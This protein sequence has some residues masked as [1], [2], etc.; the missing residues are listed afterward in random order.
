MADLSFEELANLEIT[1]VSKRAQRLSD[2]AASIFVITS[3]DIRRSGVTSLPEALRLA[4]NLQVAQSSATA[5]AISARG[6]NNNTANKLLVMIDGRSVYTPLYSGVFWDVQ[7]VVLEDVERIEVISGPGGTLWGANAVNGVINIITR[8]AK[9]SEGGLIT[10]GAGNRESGSTV[11]YGG[12]L[13]TEGSYRIYAKYFDRRATEKLSGSSKADGWY[14]SQVGFRADWELPTDN[15]MLQGNAYNGSEAQLSANPVSVS[16]FNVTSRWEH[17]LSADSSLSVQAYFDRTERTIPLVFGEH[18]DIVDLQI[19]HSLVMANAHTISWGLGYRLAED[20]VSNTP[21]FGFLPANVDQHWSNMFV[22]DEVSLTRDLQ[23]TVGARVERNDYTG[24]EWLPNARL[25]WK[26]APEHLLWTAVSRTVRAPSRLD[27]DTYVPATPPFQLAGGPSF[28]S[29]VAKVVELGYRGQ[30]SQSMSLSATV[31]RADYDNLRTLELGPSGT[32]VTLG[33]G[34]QGVV[35]GVEMWGTYKASDTWRISA[36]MT[37]MSED[38]QVKAGS[39]DT[40]SVNAQAGLDPRQRWMFKSS[41]DLSGGSEL[42]CIVRSVSALAN[43]DVPAYV[44]LDLRYA[45]KP[46]S[47]L[48]FSVTGKNLG[49]S[50][51]EFANASTR[52]ELATAVFFKMVARF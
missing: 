31:F 17:A 23:L 38:L 5:Y 45:W 20:R 28:V 37:A 7:D 14:K 18:L 27:V 49:G 11:R 46:R 24:N 39:T 47:G 40:T 3:E 43:P 52:A 21:G 12:S 51:G 48:E 4:P 33:N 35:Q 25:A 19:Q 16:G 26:F 2:A 8:S 41:W 30:L 34:M 15:I 44:A 50:H 32:F 9:D 6:M 22:Q 42:D 10:A 13:G 1:S 29:E 36:G